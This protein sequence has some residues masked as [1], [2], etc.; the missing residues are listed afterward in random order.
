MGATEEKME[1]V[2]ITGI[3]RRYNLYTILGLYRNNGKENGNYYS[4]VG[5]SFP[6]IKCGRRCQSTSLPRTLYVDP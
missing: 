6:I 3:F 4:V 1:A 5:P 2:E